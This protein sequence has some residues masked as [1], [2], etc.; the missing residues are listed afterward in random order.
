MP[1]A[2]EVVGAAS[3]AFEEDLRRR[4][5]DFKSMANFFEPG[6]PHVLEVAD[7]SIPRIV[8]HGFA[9]LARV[10]WKEA[11]ELPGY[12]VTAFNLREAE[13]GEEADVVV[14]M[15]VMTATCESADTLYFS[16]E[17]EKIVASR[18]LFG[19]SNFARELM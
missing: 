7:E 8:S 17:G 4:D 13:E 12:Q 15:R 2:L 9:A 18:H 11:T 10:L 16:V 19:N 5:R 14:D 6:A 3:A 1:T